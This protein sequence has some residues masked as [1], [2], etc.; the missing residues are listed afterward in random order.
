MDKSKSMGQVFTTKEVVD[1]MISISTLP[2]RNK[3]SRVLEPS[4]GDGSFLAAL[5][6]KGFT[7]LTGYE[8]DPE[9]I[10]V[11]SNEVI[12]DDFLFSENRGPYSVCIGNPPY[13]RRKNM[14][15]LLV[16]IMERFTK[17]V[18]Y[19]NSLSDF[20]FPFFIRAIERLEE[21]GELIFITPSYWLTTKYG[22]QMRRFMLDSGYMRLIVKFNEANVFNG[23]ASLD[24]IIFCF[25]KSKVAHEKPDI[26]VIEIEKGKYSKNSLNSAL[27]IHFRQTRKDVLGFEK[28]E[29]VQQYFLPQF[30]QAKNWA[31]YNPN[32]NRS[33]Q[34]NLSINEIEDFTNRKTLGEFVE[35]GNGIV[36][37]KDMA[38]KIK[39]ESA[40]NENE[41]NAT[42]NILKA[43][44]I[45]KYIH[46]NIS[47][48]IW[49]N[50]KVFDDEWDIKEK[51][52]VMHAQLSSYR[53]GGKNIQPG[54]RGL[55]ERFTYNE[56]TN[57]WDWVYLRNM[58]WLSK[59]QVKIMCPCKE[60]YDKK[61]FVR[62]CLVKGDILPLQDV[63]GMVPF[64]GT[65]ESP[66]FITAWLNSSYVFDWL[67]SKGHSRGGVLEFSEAPL[68]R[69]PYIKIDFT[70]AEEKLLHDSITSNFDQFEVDKTPTILENLLSDLI[71]LLLGKS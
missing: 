69:I 71:R 44:S 9:I 55:E 1:F 14:D 51:Y 20:S 57:W 4:C 22:E 32:G 50:E 66:E 54:K 30:D 16:E 13:I 59:S 41:I 52:P 36:T 3:A 39:D 12:N 6:K 48:Y 56:T 15:S 21:D 25:I 10:Q 31:L 58:S 43:N 45:Q 2:Q 63:T 38:F 64:E 27:D 17:E 8:I 65:N 18:G 35:I 29:N 40:L 70:S 62:F 5:E 61:G 33:N 34:L 67:V 53:T 37:G 19:V 24:T 26:E 46:G 28:N 23:E 42:K 7:S 47:K 49:L 68:M 11:C 60:R